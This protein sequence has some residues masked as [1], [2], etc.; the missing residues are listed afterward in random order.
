MTQEEKDDFASLISVVRVMRR[1]MEFNY[2]SF[3]D[4]KALNESHVLLE[5]LEAKYLGAGKTNGND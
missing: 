1:N 5:E 3:R 4:S 2:G